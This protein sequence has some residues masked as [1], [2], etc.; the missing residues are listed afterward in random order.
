MRRAARL[1]DNHK[2]IVA[3]LKAIGCSVLSLARMG[4]D[5]PDIVAGR[6]AVNAL[7][8]IKDGKKRPSKRKL[9][10]GQVEWHLAWRGQVA[11]VHTPQEAEAAMNAAEKW[12]LEE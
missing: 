1:D 5:C 11:V 2:E 12:I 6:R 8:E 3:H 9:R 7:M 4:D 10:P